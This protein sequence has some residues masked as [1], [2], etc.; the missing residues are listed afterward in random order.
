[1]NVQ[2]IVGNTPDQCPE[3]WTYNDEAA[4]IIELSHLCSIAGGAPEPVWW[5]RECG[6]EFVDD[7][8]RARDTA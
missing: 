6:H 1:M 7:V 8:Q 2:D 5:C 4:P 3:C